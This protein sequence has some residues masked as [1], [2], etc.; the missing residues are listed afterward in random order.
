MSR[1]R[2]CT[3]YCTVLSGIWYIDTEALWVSL[4]ITE[5]S[6][7]GVFGSN[8]MEWYTFLQVLMTY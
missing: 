2:G 7:D 1:A 5:W 8:Y 4:T 6:S 3:N